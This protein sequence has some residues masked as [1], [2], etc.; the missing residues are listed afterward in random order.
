MVAVTGGAE[1]HP[2][3][4]PHIL[5]CEWL[6]AER[7]AQSDAYQSLEQMLGSR[8]MDDFYMRA[9]SVRW[10]PYGFEDHTGM[11]CEDPI[12]TALNSPIRP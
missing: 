10:K 11:T 5:A 4:F 2:V 9:V 12:A 6:R 8:S 1:F 3:H 7:A